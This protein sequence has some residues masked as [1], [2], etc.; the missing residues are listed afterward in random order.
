[1]SEIDYEAHYEPLPPADR[2]QLAWR[3]ARARALFLSG[4]LTRRAPLLGEYAAENTKLH[5]WHDED[6]AALTEMRATI[7][8]L[9]KERDGFRDQR[10]AVFADNEQLLARIEEATEARLWAE[11]EA[12]AASHH[13][14][15][16]PVPA[17]TDLRDHCLDNPRLTARIG[18]PVRCPHCPSD[19]APV[20]PTHWTKHVQRHHPEAPATVPA[21]ADLRA[22]VTRALD[23]AFASFDPE[24][25]EDAELSGHLA[26]AV[27]PVLLARRPF[28]AQAGLQRLADDQQRGE[29]L[30]SGCAHCGG[31]HAWD[32]CE[33]YTAVVRDDKVA[34]RDA[35]V[36]AT[37][38]QVER[39][40]AAE[41]NDERALSL[42]DALVVLRAKLP[43]TCARSQGLHAKGCRRYVAGHEL[44]SPVRRLARAREEIRRM[45]DEAQQAMPFTPTDA[46]PPCIPD[47]SVAV[48]C[49]G[50]AADEAQ[51]AGSGRIVARR[52][53]ATGSVYCTT[54]ATPEMTPL[55][56][57]DLPDGAQC[58]ICGID[59]LIEQAGESGRG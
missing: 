39:A 56:S 23:A 51:Q 50:C 6:R 44:L 31:D 10:N 32:D 55:T 40:F 22:Q 8:R 30:E 7:E 17:D 2:Y 45:A 18:Y 36:A 1:M 16:P 4:E 43:C 20:P 27:L 15:V 5:Q 52:S 19:A 28:D 9:R 13:P 29:E 14:T 47:H 59:V 11:N 21:D 46:G 48:H 34:N 12:R 58:Q 42:H 3:N 38:D 35:E 53:P 24:R 33:T 26:E 57:N 37:A 54:H 41:L 49:P 25:T